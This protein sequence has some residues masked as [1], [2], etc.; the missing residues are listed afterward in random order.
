MWWLAEM[1]SA[2]GTVFEA[3][4][5][6]ALTNDEIPKDQRSLTASEPELTIA[7]ADFKCREQTNYVNRCAR[8]QADAEQDYLDTHQAEFDQLM[9]LIERDTR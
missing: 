5:G 2:D 4:L 6:Q 1:T 8:I 7:V 9:A 3:P